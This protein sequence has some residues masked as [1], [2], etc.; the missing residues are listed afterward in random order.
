MGLIISRG[1]EGRLN[2]QSVCIRSREREGMYMYVYHSEG[3]EG[4]CPVRKFLIIF[5]CTISKFSDA[6]SN[7][8]LNE[9]FQ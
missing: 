2:I 3:G 8:L 1:C 9:Y 6:A 4:E 7:E 5:I